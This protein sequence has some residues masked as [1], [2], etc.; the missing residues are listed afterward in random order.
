FQGERAPA[1]AGRFAAA[2]L[3]GFA[4]EVFQYRQRIVLAVDPLLGDQAVKQR[5]RGNSFF[6]EERTLLGGAGLIVNRNVLGDLATTLDE[7]CE[8]TVGHDDEPTGQFLPNR[9]VYQTGQFCFQVG[10]RRVSFGRERV[11]LE[12]DLTIQRHLVAGQ[13]LPFAGDRDSGIFQADV[14]LRSFEHERTG[15]PRKTA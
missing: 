11:V 13:N 8:Y 6:V 15:D 5:F 10:E 7:M 2:D 14:P 4:V 12:H 9:I 3:D 1:K